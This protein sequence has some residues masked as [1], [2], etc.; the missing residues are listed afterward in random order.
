MFFM[1]YE[2]A[3]M[4]AVDCSVFGYGRIIRGQ[5]T[6]VDRCVNMSTL[7]LYFRLVDETAPLLVGV[8]ADVCV[9]ITV[10][11]CRSAG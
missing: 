3:D 8:P 11:L 9:A 5:W 10:T 2:H 4:P 6:A 1:Q 7:T